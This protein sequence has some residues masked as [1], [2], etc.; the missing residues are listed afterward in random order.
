MSRV[1]CSAV[2][3]G[4]SDEPPYK[5]YTIVVTGAGDHDGIRR[6]YSIVG[7]TED[8][9]AIEGIRRFVAEHEK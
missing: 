3:N 1:L 2:V 7:G 6:T 5:R 4:V 8:A 9:A